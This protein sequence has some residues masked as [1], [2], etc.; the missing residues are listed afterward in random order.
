MADESGLSEMKMDPN[1][2]FREEVFTDRRI[3]TI[4]R[5][6]PVRSDGSDDPDRDVLYLG[7]TQVMTPAG[8][9][10]LSFELDAD[11]LD[12]AM[13]AFPEAAQQALEQTMDELKEMQRESAS[14]IVTPDQMGGQGGGG[15]PGGGG[16]QGGGFQ[17]R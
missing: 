11:S 8:A 1:G 15:M 2:L 12:G 9:L 4:Q 16:G 3:G 6:T 7:Q 14:R 10:P 5:L 17:L 13:E